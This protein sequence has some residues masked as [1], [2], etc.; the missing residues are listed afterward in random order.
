[1]TTGEKKR[2]RNN[3]KTWNEIGEGVMKVIEGM[4]NSGSLI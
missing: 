2:H 1:M 3:L 4:N